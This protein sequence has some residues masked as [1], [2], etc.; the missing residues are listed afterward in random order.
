MHAEVSNV[1]KSRLLSWLVGIGLVLQGAATVWPTLTHQTIPE[2]LSTRKLPALPLISIGGDTVGWFS[3]TVGMGILATL[4]AQG[5]RHGQTPVNVHRADQD[6]L[7]M[8]Q[9]EVATLRTAVAERDALRSALKD[10]QR[11]RERL[12]GLLGDAEQRELTCKR[13][14]GEARLRWFAERARMN[15]EHHRSVDPSVKDIRVTVRFAVYADLPL[16]Q[17]IQKILKDTTNWKIELDGSNKPTLLPDNK[18]FKVVFDVGAFRTFDEVAAAFNDGRLVDARLGA[19][20]T[21]RFE[22]TE[23]LIIEVLPTP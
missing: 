15:I 20:C 1:S 3:V 9:D 18:G 19:R 4:I 2:W 7:A 10:T 17:E 11:E 23:H 8:L 12:R 14:L 21:D 5:W 22:E 13:G 6:S 16:A